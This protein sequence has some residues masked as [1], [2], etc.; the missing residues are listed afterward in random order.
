MR[1]EREPMTR[2]PPSAYVKGYGE[3]CL[4]DRQTATNYVD[5]TVVGDP[6]MD[7]VIDELA[8]VPRD[9]ASRFIE[10]GME[11]DKEAIRGAPQALRDFFVHAPPP[12]PPWLDHAAFAP[13]V[14]AFHANVGS[15]LAAFVTGVLID[16]FCTLI[17]S[18]F[19]RTGRVMDRGVRRLRQ[20][21]RHMVEIFFPGGLH[22]EG[23]GWKLSVRIRFVHA[24][25]RRLLSASE[26][27]DTE[28][29]GIPVSAAHLGFAIACFSARS[30]HHSTSLGGKYTREQREGFCAVWR[31]AGHL[32]G[33][34]DT[35]L[36]RDEREAL[37]LYRIGSLC[38]PPPSDDAVIKTNALI[39]SAPAVAGIRDPKERRSLVYDRIYPIS[40]ALIGEEMANHLNFPKSRQIRS[41]GILLQFRMDTMYK[42]FMR[43]MLRRGDDSMEAVF[44]ASL[45]DS[46]GLTFR[47]PDH[48]YS[49]QS[50]NW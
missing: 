15:I 6:V 37:H 18:S 31:Y 48:T 10:A 17:S 8:A 32:M 9:Q 21:N 27:W 42:R 7:A 19:I 41:K 46:S 23:D 11:Q 40:R 43:R 16:G 29:W 12:D 3:A 26:D 20:N 34:P 14:R 13:G 24:Q 4:V 22:R 35:I 44:A 47:L 30:L 39:N 49:E 1:L 5:H 28:A 45:Y 2:P 25:V 50:S 36:F 33:I 38:E